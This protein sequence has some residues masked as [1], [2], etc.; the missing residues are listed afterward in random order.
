MQLRITK[1]AR[2]KRLAAFCCV[3]T[4]VRLTCA[5]RE[6]KKGQKSH[7]RPCQSTQELGKNQE[8]CCVGARY[9]Q[10]KGR[11]I[12]LARNCCVSCLTA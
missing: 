3:H 9:S 11:I 4:C 7:S 6:G 5:A 8:L 2:V 1:Q 12:L 10:I